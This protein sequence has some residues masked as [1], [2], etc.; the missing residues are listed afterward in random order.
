MQ[1]YCLAAAVQPRGGKIVA[2]MELKGRLIDIIKREIYPAV[3]EIDAGK[4]QSISRSEHGENR[5]ILPGLIDSH[6]HIESSMLNPG[7]FARAAVSRGTTAVVSDPHE[8][9]NVLGIPG[10]DYMINDA[11][12]VPLR[13]YFGAPSCVPA[14]AFESSGAVIDSHGIC[15]LLERPSVRYLAEMMNFPGLIGD[16]QEVWRK[17]NCAVKLGKPIDGHAPGLSGEALR[18][19]VSAGISTDH[20]CT[21]IEEAR[22][23]IKLGM[24]ILIREGSAARNLDALKGLFRTDPDKIMLCSDDLHPEMLVRGHIGRLVA[25]LVSEGYDLFD[26]VRSCT[27]NPAIHYGI[28]TGLPLAGSP[29]DLILVDDP[30]TMN[31]CQ[32]LI[33]GKKVYAEGRILFEYGGS[34]PVNNFKSSKIKKE[35]ILV[36]ASASNLRIIEAIDGDLTTGESSCNV[37]KG[38]EV[39]PRIAT[40]ILKIVV[41][42]RYRDLKPAT[43]FIRGFGLKVGAFAGSVS[44]DSHNIICIG[45]NDDDIVDA[46]NTLVDSKGGLVVA[47]NNLIDFLPLP[48]AGLMSDEPAEKVAEKYQNLSKLVNSYGCTMSAPF[49]TLSFMALLVIPRL[50]LSDRGLFDVGRF[51]Y[52]GLFFD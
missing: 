50:K 16:D 39:K 46:I 45:T 25:S 42:D 35:E 28:E 17:I 33:D 37:K 13:F 4:I 34:E 6:I 43:A 22:E 51:G 32:T 40:D 38:E 24:K 23:K 44:H 1:G 8:I 19:Y 49:M 36:E 10:V 52:T 20:E 2:A 29:A 7:S 31:V 47:K 5:F 3:I 14:T 27:I 18:K 30:R 9:A 15:E 26:V 11:S 41:K 48:V 21:T 12:K